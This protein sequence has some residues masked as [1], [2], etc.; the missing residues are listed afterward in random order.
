MSVWSSPAFAA[1]SLDKS[2][3]HSI[4]SVSHGWDRFFCQPANDYKFNAFTNHGHGSK[5]VALWHNGTTHIHCSDIES[6][7]VNAFCSSTLANSNHYTAH[8]IA[9]IGVCLDRF[10]TDGHGF[11]CHDMESL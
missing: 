7:S 1:C 4:G 5:Y 11:D 10:N 9:T 2:N 6:G 8:D 3:Q